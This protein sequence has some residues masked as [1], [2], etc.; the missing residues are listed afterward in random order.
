[1][2]LHAALQPAGSQPHPACTHSP[3]CHAHALPPPPSPFPAQ[4]A[5]SPPPPPPHSLDDLA[6]LCVPVADALV[7]PRRQ[8]AGAV[9]GEPDVLDALGVTQVAAPALFVAVHVPDLNRAVQPRRQQ[10]VPAVGEEAA[11]GGGGAG[12]RGGGG[13][14]AQPQVLRYKTPQGPAYNRCGAARLLCLLLAVSTIQLAAN[15]RTARCLAHR[16]AL[17]PL[18]CP[19]HVWMWR[20][21]RKHCSASARDLSL[22]A[23]IQLRPAPA[24]RGVEGREG[25]AERWSERVSVPAGGQAGWL[26]CKDRPLPMQQHPPRSSKGAP[27]T[28]QRGTA[29]HIATQHPPW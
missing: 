20:L 21:G 9:V 11:G 4:S 8:E 19:L 12:C 13:R 28:A 15:Q 6:G 1:M 7:V 26:R 25:R 18:L 29:R 16:I 2:Q 24:P 5:P 14:S 3:A 22:G 10:Q 17:T 27:S 23:A